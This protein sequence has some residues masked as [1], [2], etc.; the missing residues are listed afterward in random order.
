MAGED[1]YGNL[2]TALKSGGYYEALITIRDDLG[3]PPNTKHS[4]ME[5]LLIFAVKDIY[6]DELEADVALMAVGLLA[7]FS[8]TQD[9]AEAKEEGRLYSGRREN[10]LR[11]T[12][13]IEKKTEGR[14]HSYAEAADAIKSRSG[15]GKAKTEL[16]TIRNTLGKDDKRYLERAIS[17][18]Y[19]KKE[20]INEYI[21]AAKKDFQEAVREKGVKDVNW[22]KWNRIPKEL[23]PTLK[24]L[25]LIDPA[26]PQLPT[27]SIKADPNFNA[28]EENLDTS[29]KSQVLKLVIWVIGLAILLVVTVGAIILLFTNTLAE[30]QGQFEV[31]TSS[32]YMRLNFAPLSYDGHLDGEIIFNDELN[33]SSD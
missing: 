16:D 13:F 20:N 4:E 21:K 7:D 26:R 2:A 32:C 30:K 3:L 11:Q 29:E 31:H 10:F 12:D 8:R 28:R 17:A 18:L 5:A 22:R 9:R 14:L 33:G 25:K 1:V 23:L 15:D 19:S 24:Y 6:N 27:S